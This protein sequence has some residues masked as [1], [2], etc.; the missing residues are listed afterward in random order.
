MILGSLPLLRC[1]WNGF[2]FAPGMAAP[3]PWSYSTLSW[4]LATCGIRHLRSP[5]C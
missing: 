3:K 4:D 1:E 5:L 2:S